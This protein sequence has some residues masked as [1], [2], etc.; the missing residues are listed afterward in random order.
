MLQVYYNSIP[1]ITPFPHSTILQKTRRLARQY[2][3]ICVY[4]YDKIE[5]LDEMT[6][7]MMIKFQLL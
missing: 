5:N 2:L 7:Y 6:I 3:Q 1:R 4:R